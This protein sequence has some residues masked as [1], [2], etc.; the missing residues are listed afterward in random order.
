[1]TTTS[2]NKTPPALPTSSPTTPPTQTP[3]KLI[4]GKRSGS[5]CV[6]KRKAEAAGD[7]SPQESPKR[8]R[9]TPNTPAD[10]L[11]TNILAQITPL[12]D[13]HIPANKDG[14]ELEKVEYGNQHKNPHFQ[15]AMDIYKNFTKA[16]LYKTRNL[17]KISE[18]LAS[19]I[20]KHTKKYNN[21]E[22]LEKGF[23]C[24]LCKDGKQHKVHPHYS[25]VSRHIAIDHY[26]QLTYACTWKDCKLGY[27]QP[28]AICLHFILDHIFPQI[29][30]PN[31]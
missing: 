11:T 7:V 13:L 29:T 16:Q 30:I 26:H 20:A 1:M 10:D 24:T 25:N 17:V 6:V 31:M 15:L 14:V 23:Q 22:A 19:D 21:I 28:R 3:T 9:V 27:N 12:M 18:Q 5:Y 4:L 2:V 8:R